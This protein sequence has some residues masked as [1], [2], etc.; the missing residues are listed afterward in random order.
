MLC[1]DKVESNKEKIKKAISAKIP[2]LENALK[3]V[4]H[5]SSDPKFLDIKAGDDI[6][7]RAAEALAIYEEA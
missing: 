3:E 1:T 4:E 6:K 7:A 2:V 5:L